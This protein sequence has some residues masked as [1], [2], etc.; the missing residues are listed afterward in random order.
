[1]ELKVLKLSK[2]ASG[3]EVRCIDGLGI[4]NSFHHKNKFCP[5]SKHDS[6]FKVDSETTSP[7][8]AY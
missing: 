7:I 4:I 6:I 1:M 2:G 3:I 8:T 5:M